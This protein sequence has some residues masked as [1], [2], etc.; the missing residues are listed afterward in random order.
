M[1]AINVRSTGSGKLLRLDRNEIVPTGSLVGQIVRDLSTGSKLFIV[2][3]EET[4]VN[5]WHCA[6]IG[7][8]D[9]S[10][11]MCWG[12]IDRFGPTC[13]SCNGSG[14]QLRFSYE[15][16]PITHEDAVLMD[17]IIQDDDVVEF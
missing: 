3:E 2:V 14:E 5:C 13:P 16:M 17:E 4:I 10:T 12:H 1:Y 6:G 7:E 15:L 9:I 8:C 11:E